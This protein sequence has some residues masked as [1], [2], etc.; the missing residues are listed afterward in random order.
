MSETRTDKAQRLA[1]TG[2]VQAV[3]R[4]PNYIKAQVTGTN[5]LY[6]VIV[7]FDGYYSCTCKWGQCRSISK[8]FCSHAIALQLTLEKETS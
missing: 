7:F 5:D 4:Y 2:C 6:N 3:R 8:D 1:D